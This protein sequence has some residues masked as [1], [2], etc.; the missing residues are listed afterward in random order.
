MRPTIVFSSSD[1]SEFEDDEKIPIISTV[2]ANNQQNSTQNMYNRNNSDSCEDY[3]SE[4]VV[5]RTHKPNNTIKKQ[6]LQPKRIGPPSPEKH[7][8]QL[9]EENSSDYESTTNNAYAIQENEINIRKRQIKQIIKKNELDNSKETNKIVNI[10]NEDDDANKIENIKDSDFDDNLDKNIEESTKNDYIDDG[11]D[12]EFVK[13]EHF[14]PKSSVTY[15]ISRQF[16]TSIRG[17]RYYYY[18]YSNSVLKYCAKAKTRHPESCIQICEGEN[19]HVKCKSPYTLNINQESTVFSLRKGDNSGEEMMILKIFANSAMLMLPRHVDIQILPLMGIPSMLLT[20]KRPKLSAR[21]N[22]IL[23]FNNK[24]T[25]PSEKNMIFVS[26]KDIDGAELLFIRKISSNGM[27]IDL[28]TD[29][30]E[31]G[32]FAIGLSIFLAKFS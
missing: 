7:I 2:N 13:I 9:D 29:M 30:P 8:I 15:A 23:D 16:K 3:S 11:T 4:I 14:S 10:D 6:I 28:C 21:G 5:V 12:H 17:K 25:I 19:A 18:F 1:S 27:E 22:W 26:S 31:I 32:V 24:F 20:T